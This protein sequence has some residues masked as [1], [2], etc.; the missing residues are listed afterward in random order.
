MALETTCNKNVK[1]KIIKIRTGCQYVVTF[2]TAKTQTGPHKTFDWAACGARV[3]H[4]WFIRIKKS[5]CKTY[6]SVFPVC[7][8]LV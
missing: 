1:L 8:K 2:I 7:D 6:P 4:S 3:G 5:I